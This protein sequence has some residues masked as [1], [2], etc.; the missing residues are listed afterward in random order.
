M[1]IDDVIEWCWVAFPRAGGGSEA[2]KPSSSGQSVQVTQPVPEASGNFQVSKPAVF[3]NVVV[4]LSYLIYIV[5]IAAT[6][7]KM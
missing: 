7:L 1:L 2:L 3:T 5:F 4:L 6:E